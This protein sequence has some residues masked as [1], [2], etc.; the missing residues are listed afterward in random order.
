MKRTS[1]SAG[2][3]TAVI[4]AALVASGGVAPATADTTYPSWGDVQAAKANAAT[5]QA[6]VDKIN[7]LL[8][9]LQNASTAASVLAVKRAGE[10]GLAE[11]NL[12]AAT[13]K[14]D[15]L[16]TRA[17]AA[18][19]QASALR[20]QSG[21]FAEQLSRAGGSAM[22]LQ[23]FLHGDNAKTTTTLLYRL[24][25]VA[26]LGDQS[27]SLFA[28][29]N[30]QMNVAA[31]LSNQA[32][33]AQKIRNQLDAQ[34][35]TALEVAKAAQIAA[36][37]LLVSQQQ[38][39]TTMYAQLALL[40]NTE[41]SVEQ[42]YAEG[43]AKAAADAAAA[44]AAGN[45]GGGGGWISAPGDVVV[46]PA[47]AQAYAFGQ[48]GNYGWGSDQIGCLRSLWNQESGWRANAVNP[49][50]DA[51]G[52]PQALPPQKMGASG[53]DWLTNANTQINWG[54]AYIRSSYGSPCGA[55]AH[56]VSHNWY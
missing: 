24:G 7:A 45:N 43:V 4:V 15:D 8:V 29:A 39:A 38:T 23:L 48:L 20:T 12:K 33:A 19:A 21:Q 56:E 54:L 47:A 6:E 32:T 28:A 44:A 37:A 16:K 53:P 2:A 22:S 41:A 30:A 34:A 1:W 13:L 26:K 40:Q 3:V 5:A 27:S 31:S 14:A 35:K 18:T 17:D 46:D 9:Q 11:L 55:W 42:K 50:S 51:Y 36:Q 25:V 52:I 10:Y 49:S